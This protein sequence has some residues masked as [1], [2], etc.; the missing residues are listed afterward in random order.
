MVVGHFDGDNIGPRL[1]LFLLDDRLDEASA[2]SAS[3]SQAMR[4]LER[5][6]RDGNDVEIHIFGGDD[7]VASWPDGSIGPEEIDKL[8]R[9]FQSICGQTLSIGI[10]DSVKSAVSNLR[11]AKLL[12]KDR[13]VSTAFSLP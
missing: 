10:G 5:S 6:L 11:R 3:V 9:E 8:R 1:E 13:V 7:L 12:G 2:Y 4:S